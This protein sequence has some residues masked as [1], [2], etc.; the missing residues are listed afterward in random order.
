VRSP[1]N[2]V[3]T[4]AA[5]GIGGTLVFGVGAARFIYGSEAEMINA[6]YSA[7]TQEKCRTKLPDSLPPKIIFDVSTQPPGTELLEIQEPPIN[8]KDFKE[9]TREQAEINGLT[10][11]PGEE[12]LEQL[13]SAEN[14][15]EMISAL[16]SHTATK[17]GF[18]M[19]YPVGYD[20]KDLPNLYS[21]FDRDFDPQEFREITK[22]FIKNLEYV[23]LEVFELAHINR[24]VVV[25]N[26]SFDLI[27]ELISKERRP[28]AVYYFP[29]DV[30]YIEL[31]EDTKGKFQKRFDFTFSA[32]VDM[33]VCGISQVEK[34]ED[35][36]SLGEVNITKADIEMVDSEVVNSLTLKIQ[37][38]RDKAIINRNFISPSSPIDISKVDQSELD[39]ILLQVLRINEYVPG[40]A[41]FWRS[42]TYESGKK[43]GE[44]IIDNI[45]D[46]S[47]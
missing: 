32:A 4:I 3:G 26:N 36:M 17:F 28:S 22:D 9:H 2:R 19:E 31:N 25:K 40:Y 24:V 16:N 12:V 41:D 14:I 18:S 15:S 44:I 21:P 47:V 46:S 42:L 34:Y 8:K 45:S 20:F 33:S 1:D 6:G 39:T 29:K 10:I 7:L 23:P 13:D 11:V 5:L 30:V 27:P 43:D 35:E 38:I 37:N